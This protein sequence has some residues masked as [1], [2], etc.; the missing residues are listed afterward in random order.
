MLNLNTSNIRLPPFNIRNVVRIDFFTKEE[1]YELF[2]QFQ[3]EF[4]II[5]DS[6]VIDEI[7]DYTAGQPGLFCLCGRIIQE[8]LTSSSFSMSDWRA[9]V[10]DGTLNKQ[11]AFYPSIRRVLT[12][13][14]NTNGDPDFEKARALFSMLL[15]K[16]DPIDTWYALD[17][18]TNPE[19]LLLCSEGLI[20]PVNIVQ[21]H[22]KITSEIVRDIFFRIILQPNGIPQK[23]VYPEQFDLPDLVSSAVQCFDVNVL[24][25]C[26]K[27]AAKDVESPLKTFTGE[28]GLRE[29]AYHFELVSV[30]HHWLTSAVD[31]QMIVHAKDYSKEI[32]RYIHCLQIFQG[33]CRITFW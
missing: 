1:A 18:V 4:G 24:R 30:L 7:F 22:F 16:G 12:D 11:V 27:Y 20:F 13:F 23:N 32:S 6:A 29:S 17:Y 28:K 31:M 21:G 14:Q 15:L 19:V 2:D 3:M 25:E 33:D 5:V 8:A 9:L 10:L 26:Y